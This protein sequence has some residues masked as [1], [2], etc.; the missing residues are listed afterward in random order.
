MWAHSEYLKLLRSLTDG[1]VFDRIPV[2]ADRYLVPREDRKYT[3]HRHIYSAGRP[4]RT[5]RAGETLRI[6][7]TGHF[8]VVYTV[9]DWATVN[10]TISTLIGYTGAYVDIP[11]GEEQRGRIIFTQSWP[12]ENQQE[13]WLGHNNRDR[14]RSPIGGRWLLKMQ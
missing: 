2:V 8:R 1:K 7:D 10:Q 14:D 3:N 12:G 6:V 11:T 9:D 4:V 5:I 13:R